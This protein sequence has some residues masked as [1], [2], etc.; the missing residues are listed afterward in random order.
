MIIKNVADIKRSNLY[1]IAE[2]CK[3]LNKKSVTV[4]IHKKDN[5][6][7]ANGE[8][9]A[10]VGLWQEFGTA[11]IPPRM[12]LRIFI[13]LELYKKELENMINIGLKENDNI[14]GFLNDIGGYMKETI[15]ERI[16]SNSILPHSK[17]D[18]ITLVDTGQLVSSI[19]YEVH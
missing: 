10:E 5:K 6:R 11:T 12:W 14:K 1:R 7:Y 18:G 16:L 4:G 19:D 8:T 17:K 3:K 2:K 15:K 9:T 13:Y